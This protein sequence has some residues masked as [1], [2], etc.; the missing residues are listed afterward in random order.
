[1]KTPE[2]KLFLKQVGK[3]VHFLNTVVVGLSAVESGDV[4]K[5]DA[6]DISWHPAN[7]VASS[8]QARAF[9]MRSTLVMVAEELGNYI[10]RTILSPA[11]LGIT[12]H[13]DSR[14]DKLDALRTYFSLKED[15]LFLGPLLVVHWRNRIIHS[16]SKANLT[17]SQRTILIEESPLI[18]GKY[19]NL[20][21]ILLLD[22]FDK[23]TPTLKDV[24]SL[25]AMTINFVKSID[26]AIPEPASKSEV[27]KWIKHLDLESELDRVKRVSKNK[28]KLKQGVEVF[29]DTYFPSLKKAYFQ[30]CGDDV[31]S[32]L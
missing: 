23:N 8:R 28:G 13:G 17:K 26:Q 12:C 22:H 25:V 7:V 27:M 3:V 16:N 19:K 10:S 31:Q 18:K 30:Y 5:P 29:L 24:S 2:L 9:V 15:H 20:D 14:S 6:I 1:M 4:T 11:C 21:P 32:M